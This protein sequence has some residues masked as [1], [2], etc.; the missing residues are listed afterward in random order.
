MDPIKWLILIVVVAVVSV[1]GGCKLLSH[2]E[3]YLEKKFEEFVEKNKRR[4]VL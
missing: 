2:Y 1:V 3:I 4:W